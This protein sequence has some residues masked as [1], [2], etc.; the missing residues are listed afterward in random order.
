MLSIMISLCCCVLKFNAV[1]LVV[2]VIILNTESSEGKSTKCL[3]IGVHT[4]MVGSSL[5]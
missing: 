5:E 1:K 3:D 4:R 2:F